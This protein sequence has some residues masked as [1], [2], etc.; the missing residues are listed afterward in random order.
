[1]NDP[2]PLLTFALITYNQTAFVAEAV[3]GALAQTYTPL[4]IIPPTTAHPTTPSR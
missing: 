2:R 3:R 1:M 4:E